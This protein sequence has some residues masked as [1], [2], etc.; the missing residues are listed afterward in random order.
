MRDVRGA[1]VIVIAKAP[2]PGRSKTRL[3][4]PC[5]AQQA[6]RLAEAAFTDTLM[7]VAG[8]RA[9]RRVV[10]LDGEPDGL[11]PEGFEV[12]RQCTGGLDA[13]IAQAFE[14][15]GCP[16]LLI[17]MDTPQVTSSLLDEALDELG[18]CDAVLGPASDGGFWALGIHTPSP[19]VVVG[20]PM[21]RT[22][23]LDAQ[24]RRLRCLGLGYRELP[25]LSDVDTFEDACDVADLI[26][27]S[28]FAR[29]VHAVLSGM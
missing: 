12:L 22:D 14:D 28:R 1:A 20:V 8:C 6:A 23:T 15:A 2:E 16:A 3:T 13:R 27:R 25:E 24:R 7:A 18:Q 21:S 9:G 17:G 19:D 10:V 11:V 29:T 5:T 26:P 4:P